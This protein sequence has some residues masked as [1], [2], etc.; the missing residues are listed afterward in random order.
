LDTQ[1]VGP[2]VLLRAGD[3]E[4]W[5]AWRTLRELS[6][7]F[8]V[9]W[10]PQWPYNCLSHSFYCSILRR[11]Y[12]EWRAGTSFAFTIFVH[13]GETAPYLVGGITLSDVQ[14]AD[15]Q[16]GTIG[17]WMGRP[18]A[19]QGLMTEAVGLVCAFAFETLHLQRV[20]ASCL[21]HNDRSK[22]LLTRMAFE[23]EGYAKAYLQINGK[24]EDHLLWG[25]SNPSSAR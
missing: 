17:Y 23:Q 5:R 4:N 14:Y 24:R 20:E 7:D 8:L 1:L 19:G 22:A 3:I 16:K 2:R 15:A 12:R 13:D 21:P 18:Y 11:Q 9:P 10:E 6:R 25:K